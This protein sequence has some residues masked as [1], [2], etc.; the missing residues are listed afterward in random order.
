MQDGGV[1]SEDKTVDDATLGPEVYRALVAYR[2]RYDMLLGQAGS[3]TG[4]A[5]ALAEEAAGLPQEFLGGRSPELA[6]FIVKGFARYSIFKLLNCGHLFCI[7]IYFLSFY[8]TYLLLDAVVIPV[9]RIRSM[10]VS[11]QLLALCHQMME[12]Y[13]FLLTRQYL[14][15]FP[16]K[17]ILLL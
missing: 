8:Y 7:N 5:A 4:D 13:P 6:A 17:W 9:M 11:I 1:V 2:L 15:H 14:L 10:E 16:K 3:L 12:R